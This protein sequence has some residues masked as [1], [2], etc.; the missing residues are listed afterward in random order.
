MQML[1]Y[2]NRTRPREGIFTLNLI[3]GLVG[4][5][6]GASFLEVSARLV[7]LGR[8]FWP[9]QLNLQSLHPD[10]EPVHCLDRRLGTCRV[11]KADKPEALALV[12]RPVD[13]HLRKY[14]A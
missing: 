13:E 2:Q 7:R 6:F 1:Q 4:F 11:V 9:F 14:E 5:C 10:L 3:Q 8:I 12:G